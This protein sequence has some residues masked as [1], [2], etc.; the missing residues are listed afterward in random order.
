VAQSS[1]FAGEIASDIAEV[2]R[3]AGA[4]ADSSTQVSVNAGDLTRLAADLKIMIGEF[5]V[6]WSADAADAISA[7]NAG[8]IKWDDSIRV[9]IDTIDRQ[10]HRLVDMV[11]GLY[12][13]MRKRAA[14]TVVGPILE[15]LARYTVEHFQ[16]EEKLMEAAGYAELERHRQA[17]ERLVEKVL[18]FKGRF[19]KGSATLTLDLMSFLSDWLVNHIKG[20]DR[21]Y[22]ADIKRLQSASVHPMQ[23][24]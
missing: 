9:G 16:T 17:H 14:K 22:V 15:E 6:E 11:N 10:H 18:D 24:A 23:A 4:I 7:D 1:T 5:K 8:L 2:N 13:A 3:I 12:N 19:D 21:K 20:V